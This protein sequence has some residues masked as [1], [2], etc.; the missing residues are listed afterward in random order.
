MV[1][2]GEKRRK[3]VTSN[4]VRNIEICEATRHKLGS[5]ADIGTCRHVQG[6]NVN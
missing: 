1:K 6:G 4:G 5:T 3:K 2:R